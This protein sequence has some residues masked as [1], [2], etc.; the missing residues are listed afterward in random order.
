[1]ATPLLDRPPAAV[2]LAEDND[3]DV[4]LMRECFKRT[5]LPVDLYA[6]DNGAKCL[7]F[8]RKEGRYQDAPTPDLLLLDLL[9]PVMDGREVLTE[10][11]ADE[12]LRQLP[13]IILTAYS[14]AVW[15]LYQL[16]C[17]AFIVKPMGIEHLQH[18]IQEIADFWFTIV[19]LPSH[20][21]M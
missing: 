12:R 10:I 21:V 6:V 19:K 4:I 1:M 13:V 16:G 17:N 18:V 3:G 15:E 8:L 14:Q 5:P 20:R 2:L 7:A 11:V 9:M